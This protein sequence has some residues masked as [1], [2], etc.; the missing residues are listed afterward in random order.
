[1]PKVLALR[2]TLAA[3]TRAPNPVRQNKILE[4]HPLE[5]TIAL[6]GGRPVRAEFLVFGKPRIEE[7]EIQEIVD[8]LKSGWISTGP[9]VAKFAG[10]FREYIGSKHA[11]PLNSCTAG[12]HLA[13]LV[14][15]VQPGDE[16][17]TSPLT[18][19]AS[20]NTVIH[21]GARPVFVDVDPHTCLIK[22]GEIEAKITKKTRAILPVHFAGRPC[23]MDTILGIAR[24]HN[25]L[26]IDDAAHAIE[27]VFHGH[28]VGN[29]ADLTAFSFYVTKNII[30][31]EGGMV[32]TNN[33]EWAEKIQI[34][35][36]HGMNKDAW[37]RYSGEGFKH[38]QIVYPGYK[39]NLMDLQAS[40]GIHQ[41]AR[42]QD[43]L[44][45]RERVWQAYD[46]AFRDLPLYTPPP[47]EPDTIH[48]RHLYTPMLDLSRLKV[49][50]DTVM[51]ALQKENI[52]TGIHFISLHQHEYYRRTFG[53][54][55]EDFPHARWISERTISLPLSAAL[56][57]QD[58]NDV[59][60]AV[61][62]VLRY[63]QR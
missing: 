39:Y 5:Q 16:V 26:V 61:R 46:E 8:C 62:K 27:T 36:L 17:I 24:R 57:E 19:A 9:R 3:G 7:A 58:V 45:I 56:T 1:M 34:Y 52:G 6:A 37:K 33:A 25:L 14:A 28:K 21:C 4:K 43:Y 23:D 63:Y 22:A 31:G 47:A 35:G 10:L 51:Q 12:L 42:V 59:I 41:L 2:S 60:A 11:V 48:A 13:M 32:T 54:Q 15:G 29:I 30:T 50:R 53:F 20:A 18:F 44:K 49:D 40:L 55:P 38:Y